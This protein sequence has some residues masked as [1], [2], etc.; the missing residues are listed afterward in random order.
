VGKISGKIMGY[1]IIE[2][3]G[4]IDTGIYSKGW[5]LIFSAGVKTRRP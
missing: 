1:E 2:N 4:R 3:R 5:Q